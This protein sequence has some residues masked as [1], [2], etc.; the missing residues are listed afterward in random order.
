MHTRVQFEV[1]EDLAVVVLLGTLFTD[2]YFQGR[3]R[4]E[5]KLVPWNSRLMED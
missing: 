5:Y 4:V 1:V 3:F 2:R